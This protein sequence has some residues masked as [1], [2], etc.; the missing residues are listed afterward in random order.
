MLLEDGGGRFVCNKQ[1]EV[2]VQVED[3]LVLAF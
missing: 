3:E 2:Y 1:V